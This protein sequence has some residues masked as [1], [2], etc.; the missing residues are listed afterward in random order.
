MKAVDVCAR[1]ALS[2]ITQTL[3]A[4]GP[5]LGEKNAVVLSTRVFQHDG[6]GGIREGDQA[7]VVLGDADSAELRW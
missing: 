4:G 7:D 3:R 1:D 5:R 6:V 2:R